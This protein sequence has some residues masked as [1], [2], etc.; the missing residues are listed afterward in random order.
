MAQAI[1][2]P[3]P[4]PTRIE[5]LIGS[6]ID[7]PGGSGGTYRKWEQEQE[8]SKLNTSMHGTIHEEAKDGAVSAPVPQPEPKS[9]PEPTRIEKLIGSRIDAPGGSGGTYR[10]WIQ[11]QAQ[12]GIHEEANDDVVSAFVPE[13]EPADET[14][15]RRD[16]TTLKFS[17]RSAETPS[18]PP[19]PMPD[20][21][22]AP[23]VA[24]VPEVE[25]PAEAD[26]MM[27]FVTQLF[28]NRGVPSGASPLCA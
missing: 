18:A 9:P 16:E 21:V 28:T 10:K 12:Q 14:T 2:S 17:K 7:A 23:A 20:L 6:R 1:S 5:K 11:E 26:G 25:A 8:K 3:E 13:P 27:G 22:T 15:L 24:A 4:Q 19:A